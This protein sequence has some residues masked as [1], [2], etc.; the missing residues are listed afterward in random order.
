MAYATCYT[1]DDW[2][3]LA[4]AFENMGGDWKLDH[5]RRIYRRLG[6]RDQYLELRQRK[7]VTGADDHDL[8]NFHWKAGEKRKAMAVAEEGLRQGKGRMDELREF[9]AKRAK[10]AG[11]RERYSGAAIRTGRRPID[12]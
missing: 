11:N 5:A 10:S 9:V 7:L 3:A 8:A 12:L 4:K 2:R 6:D 1:D